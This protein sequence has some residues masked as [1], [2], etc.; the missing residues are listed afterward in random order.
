MPDVP[1]AILEGLGRVSLAPGLGGYAEATAGLFR[2]WGGHLSGFVRGEIGWKPVDNISFFGFSQADGV[3]VQTGV[4][5]RLQ[6]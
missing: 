1:H 6:F 5:A 3:G 2:P 4:G